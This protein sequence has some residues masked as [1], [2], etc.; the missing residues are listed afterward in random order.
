MI[1][2]NKS[3]SREFLALLVIANALSFNHNFTYATELN[4]SAP[5]PK[6][7]ALPAG[8]SERAEL[9]FVGETNTSPD[10]YR[11]L[12]IAPFRVKEGER[13]SFSIWSKDPIGIE[14]VITTIKTDIG[15][16]L[17]FLKLVEG[18]EK[19]GRWQGS[20]VTKNIS[21]SDR[22]VTE[23]KAVNKDGKEVKMG[24]VWYIKKD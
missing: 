5:Q 7:I 4:S 16:K 9:F 8:F 22:Y 6:K 20:W 10:F 2:L 24:C 3:L 15:Q 17:F 13:Q 14:R 21:R 12:I 19:A 23:F 18:T 1:I 11:E